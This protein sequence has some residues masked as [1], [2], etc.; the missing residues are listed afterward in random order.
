M[1]KHNE[2]LLKYI[3]IYDKNLNFLTIILNCNFNC[4]IITNL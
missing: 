2:Y 4:I 1:N 3:Y